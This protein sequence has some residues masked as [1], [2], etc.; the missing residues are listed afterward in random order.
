MRNIFVARAFKE[1][2]NAQAWA[3]RESGV[4]EL[5]YGFT[6]AAMIYA[7]AFCQFYDALATTAKDVDFA[8]DD[9][10]VLLMILEEIE[11]SAFTPILV[12]ENSRN[13]WRE[14]GRIYAAHPAL[15]DLPQSRNEG[16]YHSF[17][18]ATE[19]FAIAHEIC[20]HLLGHTGVTHRRRSQVNALVQERLDR[21]GAQEICS[22]LNP[23]QLQ[24]IE[25]D[26]GAFLLIAG[27]L[28]GQATRGRIYRSLAGSMLALVTLGHISENW[29]SREGP[30]E[31]H[32]GFIDR[33][34]V[35]SRIVREFTIPLTRGSIGDHPLG[36]LLQFQ[37]FISIVLQFWMS[38]A[39]SEV[40]DPHFLNIFSWMMDQAVEL[41]KE[42]NSRHNTETSS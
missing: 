37:G 22:N 32:P 4:V 39:K 14:S 7:T 27:E 8:D 25:A 10:E 20:H 16:D 13:Q 30:G 18:S 3:F 6:S 11:N 28:S 15:L 17:V 29:I 40:K 41:E 9:T 42:L 2:A 21:S 1:D 19:E 24:E 38:R 26:V 5:N 35:M 12:A 36:L 33:F 31:T 34:D 23:D